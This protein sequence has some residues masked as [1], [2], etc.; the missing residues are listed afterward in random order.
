MSGRTRWTAWE[1]SSSWVCPPHRRQIGASNPAGICPERTFLPENALFL[2]K[3]RIDFFVFLLH[4][5]SPPRL[6]LIRRPSALSRTIHSVAQNGEGHKMGK[7]GGGD[8]NLEMRKRRRAKK[9]GISEQKDA[10]IGLER[11]DRNAP[12]P[13]SGVFSSNFLTVEAPWVP[14][15]RTQKWVFFADYFPIPYYDLKHSF[16]V[17]F[18]L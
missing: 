3:I 4:F 16:F 13:S 10:V 17:F 11:R 15:A 18:P 12:V 6:P 2:L 5:W 14:L 8:G 9:W 7:G 1:C